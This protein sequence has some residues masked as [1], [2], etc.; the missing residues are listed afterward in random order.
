MNAVKSVQA[1]NDIMDILREQGYPSY[2]RL[3]DKF[4][5]YLTDKPRFVGAMVPGKGTIIL[6][7][8]LNEDQISTVVRHEI[9]HEY[10]THHERTQQFDKAH[11]DLLPDHESSNIAG[12]F[13]ISNRGYTKKDKITV[14][15]LT[16]NDELLGGLVTEDHYPGWEKM[17]FEEMYE[18]I[19]KK[20]KEDKEKIQ[21]MMDKLSNLSDEELE[22]LEK[23]IEDDLRK[24][25]EAEM[26][27]E[28]KSRGNQSNS[29][30]SGASGQAAEDGDDS[31]EENS[32][33]NTQSTSSSDSKSDDKASADKNKALKDIKKDI[34]KL[35]DSKQQ[36]GN[37]SFDTELEQRLR[38]RI[39]KKAEAIREI[40]SDSNFTP[41]LIND[42]QKN[43]QKEN[44]RIQ[45]AKDEKHR[46]DPLT[47]FKLNLNMFI[48]EQLDEIAED[49]YKRMNATYEDSD[50]FMP[51]E[52][53][54][55]REK[56]PLINVYHDVSGS[57]SSEAKTAMA[58]R[59]IDSIRKYQDQGLLE[60]KVWYFADRVS[61]TKNGAGGGTEGTPVL[62]HI[63]ATRPTNVIII[64]DS[65]ISDCRESVKVPG[66]V[67][68][69]F[70]ESR[71]QNL[72][73]H[74]KGARQTKYYDIHYRGN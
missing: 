49:S 14:R 65:D 31:S 52:M 33:Q 47:Q 27:K 1:K 6:N 40:F 5:V 59:A 38:D 26:E 22:D 32:S 72:I 29:Q 10:F 61:S 50:F 25:I 63:K 54:I 60:M 13:D 55:D 28:G 20:R 42:V 16:L 68:M 30:N 56:I 74:L 43:R 34:D 2:A 36:N 44:Q 37:S 7:E 58:M 67:W 69:L 70:Y 62:D 15:T 53:G 64:T 48:S 9:L 45:A 3:L 46:R 17:T 73:D 66:A 41:K 51:V 4:D 35:K 23:Q 57:F 8:A 21:S 24:E 12:D 11:S 39:A 71:S 19:L 18:E